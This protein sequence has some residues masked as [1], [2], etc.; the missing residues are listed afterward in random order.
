MLNCILLN[1][2]VRLPIK[3]ISLNYDTFL[4]NEGIIHLC[5]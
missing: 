1:A 3:E 4:P 5:I 2:D